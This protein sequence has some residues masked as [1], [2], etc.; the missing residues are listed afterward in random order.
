MTGVIDDEKSRLVVYNRSGR[1]TD[2]LELNPS[3]EQVELVKKA[4]A[5][6]D[7]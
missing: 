1:M 3:D 5:E 7:A 6:N 2:V 4:K